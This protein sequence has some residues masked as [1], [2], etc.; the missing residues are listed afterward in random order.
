MMPAI[1]TALPGCHTFAA[2]RKLGIKYNYENFTLL[3]KVLVLQSTGA[4][5]R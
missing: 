2:K 1:M 5:A 4:Y 3:R